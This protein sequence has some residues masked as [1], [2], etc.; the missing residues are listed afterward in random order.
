M[1]N[2]SVL[3]STAIT[4]P[5]T[6]EARGEAR[7]AHMSAISEGLTKRG[8]DWLSTYSRRTTSAE[9]PRRG[10]GDARVF[11]ETVDASPQVDTLP[12]P[13]LRITCVGDIAHHGMQGR[14]DLS[15]VANRG[16]ITV[17]DAHLGA[18]G[19]EARG[20]RGSDPGGAC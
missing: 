19:P 4:W 1:W 9:T 3:P 5:L 15:R 6:I 12:D 13:A 8:I 7:N 18:V 10:A 11:D 2:V 20:D 17:A 16:P 14:V